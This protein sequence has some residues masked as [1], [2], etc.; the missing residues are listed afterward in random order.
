MP[1][2]NSKNEYHQYKQIRDLLLEEGEQRC[3]PGVTPRFVLSLVIEKR[4][5]IHEQLIQG[6]GGSRL[7]T[8]LIFTPDRTSPPRPVARPA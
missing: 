5:D 4:P 3:G 2:R 7:K 8:P 6:K 1:G